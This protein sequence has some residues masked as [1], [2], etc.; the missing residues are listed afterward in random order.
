MEGPPFTHEFL[1]Q[2]WI[3]SAN[4]KKNSGTFQ[5]LSYLQSQIFTHV[6]K[7]CR[8]FADSFCKGMFF[9]SFEKM[10][11]PSKKKKKCINFAA[12]WKLHRLKLKL[13]GHHFLL[14][15][16][17]QLWITFVSFERK[18]LERSTCFRTFPRKY[19]RTFRNILDRLKIPPV[20]E[21]FF[22]TFEKISACLKKTAL[23]TRYSIYLKSEA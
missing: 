6:R 20:T 3:Q 15:I 17:L 5:K 14:N 12:L 1:L 16:S 7:Y 2:L 19:F 13:E 9:L 22:R 8:A 18:N 21:H 10:F 23:V 11:A 4:F